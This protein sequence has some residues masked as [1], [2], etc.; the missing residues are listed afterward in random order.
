M[1]NLTN[2][3]RLIFEALQKKQGET[4]TRDEIFVALYPDGKQT[5]SNGIEV[6]VRRLRVKLGDTATISTVR[7]V[8]YRLEQKAA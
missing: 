4:V 3:E 6:F 7:G 8:G 5:N 1:D 2:F